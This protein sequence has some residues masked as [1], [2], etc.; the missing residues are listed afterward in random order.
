MMA[1]VRQ[2]FTRNLNLIATHLDVSSHFCCQVPLIF[3]A[4][5]ISLW[6]L[7]EYEVLREVFWLLLTQSYSGYK[8]KLNAETK[9]S[10]TIT[11]NNKKFDKIR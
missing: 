3:Q 4:T 10:I 9:N 7:H 5:H 1:F 11:K 2:D 6:E 8:T